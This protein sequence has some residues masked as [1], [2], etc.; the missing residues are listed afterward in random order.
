MATQQEQDQA[1]MALMPKF[2]DLANQLKDEG[3]RIDWINSALQ[4]ASATYTT[5]LTAGNQGYLNEGGIEKL[6]QVYRKN[7]ELV[8]QMKKAQLGPEGM[9]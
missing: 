9:N 5:Y 7:L 3:H 1:I 4:M 8:Q 6:T 2:I